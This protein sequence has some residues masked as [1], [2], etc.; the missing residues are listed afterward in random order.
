MF[1]KMKRILSVFLILVVASVANTTALSESVFTSDSQSSFASDFSNYDYFNNVSYDN[2]DFDSERFASLTYST[3]F[4]Y[5]VIVQFEGNSLLDEY[6][7]ST[8]SLSF[9]E[10]V[11]SSNSDYRKS[12]ISQSQDDFLV[13][14][15][16]EGIDYTLNY[17]YNSVINGVSITVAANQL[18]YIAQF[19]CVENMI[20]SETYDIP[21]YEVVDNEV[22]TYSTGIYDP[23]GIGYTGAGVVVAVLDTGL[24][25]THD[26][27]S[28]MPA[29]PSMTQA[30]VSD[31]YDSLAATSLNS[32][33][34]A[35][36][37]YVNEKVPYVFDY[38]DND[39]DVF[40]ANSSHGLHVS[41]IIAGLDDG[42]VVDEET[43]ETFTGVAPDA[44]IAT[45]KVFSDYTSGAE[46]DDILAALSDCA[47][48]GV[49]IINMSLGSSCGFSTEVDEENTEAIYDMIEEIGIIL[50]VAA[51]NDGSQYT[52]GTYGSTGLTS[53]P[54]TGTVGSPST[55][56]AAL[57]VASISGV[58]SPYMVV[59][60]EII[61]YT[62]TTDSQAN[63]FDFAEE[64]LEINP[65]GV[66]NYVVVSG[67]GED[68][69]YTTEIKEA[70]SQ[71][72]TIAVV[73]RG[74][75]SFVDKQEI[76][77][78]YGAVG[79]II[80]NNVS[81]TIT[82]T[83]AGDKDIPTITVSLD[84]GEYFK[85][86]T[87]GEIELDAD[88]EA[89][90]F[91]SSFSSWGP[92]EDLLIKP[93]ITGHGGT[94]LSCVVGGYDEFSGT[95][96]AAPNIAGM[97]AL[98]CEYVKETF[99]EA[100]EDPVVATEIV[101]QLLMSTSEIAI[102]ES[103]NPYSPRLQGAGIGDIHNATTT[104]SL[105]SV[106]NSNKTKLE[107]GDDPDRT[108]IY[109]M[110]FNVE[111]FSSSSSS[112]DISLDVMTESVSSD[113]ITV[114][115]AAYMFTDSNIQVVVTGGTYANGVI[116]V[117]AN[118][119]ANVEV[120]LS[121]S[122]DAKTYLDS[123]FENGMYVEGYVNL[124]N[125]KSDGVD[126]NIPYL[127]F[128]GDW[129]D[130]D[131]FDTDAYSVSES[132]HDSAVADEDKLQ[133]ILYES[134][135]VGYYWKDSIDEDG[136]GTLLPLGSY[137]FNSDLDEAALPASS[138]EKIAVGDSE[139][140]IYS[141]AGALLGL[142]R[143][144]TTVDMVI[145]NSVTGEVIYEFTEDNCR[146]AYN[147]YG[148]GIYIDLSPA[149][150]GLSNN[151]K[152][153][154]TFTANLEYQ[155]RTASEDYSMS[156]Y[157]DYEA[158]SVASSDVRTTYNSDGDR[159]VYLDLGLYDNNYVQAYSLYCF[160]D[161]ETAY[162]LTDLIPVDGGRN[163]T[164][165]L[166]IDITTYLQNAAESY[167]SNSLIIQL[168]DYALN[169]GLYEVKLNFSD[170]DEIEIYGTD[171]DVLI[172]RNDVI[173]LEVGDVYNY[174]LDLSPATANKD[175][176]TYYV[177]NT[178]V[179]T[180]KDG[181]IYAND[182]GYTKVTITAIMPDE[183]GTY[184]QTIFYV[185]VTENTDEE[186]SS[187][188]IQYVEV[189]S[190][191]M[192]GITYYIANDSIKLDNG[193]KITMNA[194]AYPFYASGYEVVWSVSNTELASIDSV[195]GELVCL[196]E[197]NVTIR[198]TVT[199]GYTTLT[200]TIKLS[201]GVEYEVSSGY[202]LDYY[203]VG[204]DVVIPG[205]LSIYYLSAYSDSTTGPFYENEDITSVVVPEGV[206]SIGYA[207]FGDCTN[208][209]TVYLPSSIESISTGAFSGCTSL[210]NIYWLSEDIS[211]NSDTDEYDSFE[212][213]VD[214][215]Y[216]CTALNV[217]IGQY[218]FENCTSLVSLDMTKMRVLHTAAFY[219]CTSLETLE[220]YDLRSTGSY[221]FAGCTS[222]TTVYI[223]ANVPVNEY[224]FNG[225]TNLTSVEIHSSSIGYAAFYECTS[226]EDV[227]IG[228]EVESIG[229]YAFY[230]CSK[231]D[232][233][234]LPVNLE[235]VG[236]NAFFGC[237]S[238][239]EVVFADGIGEVDFEVGVFTGCTSLED[240]TLAGNSDYYSTAAYK[241]S[242]TTYTFLYNKDQTT[243]IYAPCA[244]N[245]DFVFTNESGDIVTI[246]G[247][248]AY[249]SSAVTQKEVVIPSGV[250]YIGQYAFAYTNITSMVVAASV[251]L[252]DE[253]AYFGCVYL[254]Q[255][256]FLGDL[257][258][259]SD[260]MFAYCQSLTTIQLPNGVEYIG[261]YA[262]YYCTALEEIT[263]PQSVEYL[264]VQSFVYCSSLTNMTFADGSI[265]SEIG[266]EA[267]YGA[268]S[269]TEITLPESLE[270]IGD[271]ALA[272][273]GIV[274]ITFPSNVEFGDA[275]ISSATN[276]TT[277]TFEEGITSIPAYMFSNYSSSSSSYSYNTVLT[278]VN[279]PSTLLSIE[280]A[281]FYGCSNLSYLDLSSVIY[282]APYAFYACDN[283]TTVILAD[284]SV[285]I[286][287]YGFY[288]AAVSTI[289]LEG[290]EYVGDYAFAG[291]TGL[292]AVNLTNAEYVGEGAFYS[293]SI[294]SV[295]MPKVVTIGESAFNSAATLT[296][297]TFENVE[298]IGVSAFMSTALGEVVIPSSAEY[299]GDGAFSDCSS[300][301]TISVAE[302]NTNYFSDEDGV[303]YHYLSDNYYEII[304][305]PSGSELTEYTVL[306]NTIRIGAYSF[307]NSMTLSK[308]VFPESLLTIG[309]YSFYY[310]G[311]EI[312]DEVYVMD[313]TY[314]FQSL[315]AP[316][317]E[318]E[319]YSDSTAMYY[320]YT[321]FGYNI[322]SGY[323]DSVTGETTYIMFDMI[324]PENGV[325]YDSFVYTS[326]FNE[327]TY[328]DA[329][330][331]EVTISIISSIASIL[332]VEASAE[333]YAEIQTVVTL[334]KTLDSAQKA[335]ITNY[336]ELEA[337]NEVVTELAADSGYFDE[338]DSE[339]T[340]TESEETVEGAG[341]SSNNT[342]IWVICGVLFVVVAA[343]AV[344]YVV[345]LK[346]KGRE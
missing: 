81:G 197:G 317:L 103:G 301:S 5:S 256:Y 169:S 22:S 316:I 326:Y 223:G 132:L 111:N 124:T 133:S 286:D 297:A 153:D 246:I 73:S 248:S 204:G 237:S 181:E 188:Q 154:V 212:L 71:P 321:Q 173:Y 109:R 308:V 199:R 119:T 189:P 117:A 184:A 39:A 24:D 141:F 98:L 104:T 259:I 159:T 162:T 322:G 236:V 211:W 76:A 296:S 287:A 83:L 168:Y 263:I 202:L 146:K 172:D 235:T 137:I 88:Y 225:C 113:G 66:F 55:Y 278:T 217:T 336:S 86:N 115:E 216:D 35:A 343:G 128:Y 345:I 313:M 194:E 281:A 142:M 277:V 13:Q 65:S 11:A 226:L 200:K 276:L 110:E 338:D 79:C 64:M 203:G 298:Y 324:V 6:T 10:Y 198:A 122:N 36:D 58:Q 84:A 135:A 90:P 155:G 14:L 156:F 1:K 192:D 21:E 312:V 279:L 307:I 147:G 43:G 151:E 327:P 3:S 300:L 8:T 95:S 78:E 258:Y 30:D 143:N 195:T 77:A 63:A 164:T 175:D 112:Y 288:G 34:T 57:S 163:S 305:Y 190:Y 25:V 149:A 230:G 53:T 341:E 227:T 335:F 320:Y 187:Y 282:I 7:N 54:S 97:C 240:F 346:K 302:G 40:P 18:D 177:S 215:F 337:R 342:M 89:G 325:G 68:F 50:V 249:D 219:G 314:V 304:S 121:L 37:M 94:I 284:S 2:I 344:A 91:M 334:Y 271:Y 209:K 233:I 74:E 247:D 52:S 275:V 174:Y 254:E 245:G 255:A 161:E 125:S 333:Q 31:V 332:S 328:S 46:T 38:A 42:Y 228:D 138:I 291:S 182:I 196:Q 239:E 176:V 270:Y 69:N 242:Y 134:M 171:E 257:P 105:I 264:G 253:F 41:G 12:K 185:Y 33:V 61:Y 295:T 218:C 106:D 274:E 201:I 49:D 165:N 207:T 294:T 102:N 131:L 108:G 130:Q 266:S 101:Y 319:A 166:T 48:L 206:L 272:S 315:N 269:L 47:V 15:D 100:E 16:D 222:L 208:L 136:Y 93:E 157:V 210:E 140:G 231:V 59:G 107:L 268:T 32:S 129:L 144:C 183:S 252:V 70:L 241:V 27:F 229:T 152:Y 45:F 139:Y 99:S 179:A 123:N 51:S 170:I 127:A 87:T 331:E 191:T 232:S 205:D 44:Q 75:T 285:Y 238:L 116:T 120:T 186:A 72:N 292:A 60:D 167:Y 262:F 158:P 234:T 148:S 118:Q 96:M 311:M 339:V 29:D 114:A 150:L 280:E 85:E 213:N 214:Y 126:L 265:L 309:A 178:D 267:L 299:V 92:T 160:S 303:L 220:L 82:A 4:E 318:G 329:V 67:Y 244:Y 306:E 283:L 56:S 221:V 23:E 250:E 180:V 289:N 293:S 20:L 251:A 28:T 261:D 323:T 340:D 243:L 26:A 224:M 193:T 17:K 62:E 273:T 310:C 145:V 260:G 330:K 9:E 290:V 80:Y 19:D